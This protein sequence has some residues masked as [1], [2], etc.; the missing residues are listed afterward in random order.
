[1]VF[2]LVAYNN[3]FF[4]RFVLLVLLRGMKYLYVGIVMV[5]SRGGG[6]G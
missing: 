3:G 4:V 1:M 2:L 6:D 5:R